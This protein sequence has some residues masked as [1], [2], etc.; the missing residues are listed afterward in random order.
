MFNFSLDNRQPFTKRQL[1]PATK[2]KNSYLLSMTTL[3]INTV[4]QW[5]KHYTYALPLMCQSGFRL[6]IPETGILWYFM[7]KDCPNATEGGPPFFSW[8]GWGDAW[9]L[10]FSLIMLLPISGEAIE[11]ISRNASNDSMD[12]LWTTFSHLYVGFH[13]SRHHFIF[14]H[15][16]CLIKVLQKKRRQ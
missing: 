4:E 14:N 6:S 8:V 9:G 11:V 3:H 5:P 12:T 15:L 13:T 1:P 2:L 7:V 10:H 16:C